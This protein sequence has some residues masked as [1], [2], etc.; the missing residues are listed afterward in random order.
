MTNAVPIHP[1]SRSAVWKR[2]IG[3]LKTAF[4]PACLAVSLCSTGVVNVASSIGS[5]Q[6]GVTDLPPIPVVREPA[7]TE[8]AIRAV[9]EFAAAH[10]EILRYMPCFCVCGKTKGH[11][12][13]EQCYITSRTKTSVVWNDHAAGCPICLGVARDAR[14]MFLEGQD[15]R[16]IRRAIEESYAH[17]FANHTDTPEPPDER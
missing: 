11:R 5:Q 15:V 9:Y 7:D 2:R 6:E 10:P 1:G 14:A 17:K 4:A 8:Q 3:R 13:N 12:S 16:A